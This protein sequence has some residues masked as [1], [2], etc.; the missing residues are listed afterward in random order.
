MSVFARYRSYAWKTALVVAVAGG[1]LWTAAHGVAGVTWHDV[2]SILRSVD[3]WRLALLA[4]IWFGGLAIYS[5][6]L[7][8]ALP[9]LGVRRGLLLNLSGSAVAN[10]VPL[11]GAVATALNW[12][13][14]RTWGHSNRSFLS[15]CILT[16]V[17]DVSSKLLLPL[18]AV[19]TLVALSMQVPPVL[20]WLAACCAGVFLVALAARTLLARRRGSANPPERRWYAVAR[21]HLHDS[22]TRISAIFVG[23][24]PRLVPASIAYV[25]AQVLLLMFALRSVGL[26]APIAVVLTAAAIERLATLIP[27][28]PGGTGIAEVGTIA[29]MVA[30]GLDPVQTVAGVLLYR[31]FL[32]VMEIP[33]GGALLAGWTWLHRESFRRGAGE[34][35]A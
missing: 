32:I 30:C 11:G 22:V 34:V 3:L 16:N 21:T 8:A 6:V 24:W 14:V 23:H 27:I 20:W 7:S 9:G 1:G 25:A 28:T 15:F 13:M 33:V 5:T 4:G 26:D 10:A 17:L 31:V 35:A 12:R 29:W 19:G 2:A 18:A